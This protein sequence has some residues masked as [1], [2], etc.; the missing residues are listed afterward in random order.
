[1]TNFFI[2]NNY[3]IEMIRR[4]IITN[5]FSEFI[6]QSRHKIQVQKGL[7]EEV[8]LIRQYIKTLSQDAADEI[9]KTPCEV[10]DIYILV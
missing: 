2:K 1:M 9:L 6:H 8:F 3:L 4:I 10:Y 5:Y 7:A